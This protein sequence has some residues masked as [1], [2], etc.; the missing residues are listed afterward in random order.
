[1]HIQSS[2]EGFYRGLGF[3]PTGDF[4]GDEPEE[5]LVIKGE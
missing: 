5:K 1:M 3:E 4:Y 2:P